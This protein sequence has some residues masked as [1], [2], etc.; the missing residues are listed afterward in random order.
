MKNTDTLAASMSS[1]TCGQIG[2]VGL[3]REPGVAGLAD[4]VRLVADQDV[5]VVRGPRCR[6]G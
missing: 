4:P 2:A 3:R 6:T 5:D 1:S